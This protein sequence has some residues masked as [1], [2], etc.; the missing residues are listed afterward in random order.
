MLSLGKGSRKQ[1]QTSVTVHDRIAIIEAGKSPR[2]SREPP[3]PEGR[4][5]VPG[6]APLVLGFPWILCVMPPETRARTGGREALALQGKG[7][8]LRRE[9]GEPMTPVM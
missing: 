2:H 4:S 3:R 8:P 5:F 9:E 6:L 7:Q 1:E